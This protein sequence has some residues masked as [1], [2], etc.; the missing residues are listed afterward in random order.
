VACFKPLL[1]SIFINTKAQYNNLIIS[2]KDKIIVIINGVFSTDSSNQTDFK[3]TKLILESGGDLNFK[4]WWSTDDVGI[5]VGKGDQIGN[6]LQLIWEVRKQ[7]EKQNREMKP[8]HVD[9][10]IQSLKIKVLKVF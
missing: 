5:N 1:W 6:A 8:E 2:K 9:K 4:T 3:I 7:K 10:L